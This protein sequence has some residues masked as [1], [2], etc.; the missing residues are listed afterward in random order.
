MSLRNE[1]KFQFKA[2]QIRDAA[3]LKE[4]HH[5]ARLE[6]WQAEHETAVLAAEG[7]TVSIK[8]VPISGGDR[9]ELRIADRLAILINECQHKI[10]EHTPHVETD[11]PWRQSFQ[12]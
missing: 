3:T 12:L 11:R 5:T 6:W 7:S 8:R 1:W 2:S 9:A 10:Q 4:Q